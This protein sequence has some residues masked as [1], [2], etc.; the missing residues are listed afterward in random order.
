MCPDF[1]ISIAKKRAKVNMPFPKL[2]KSDSNGPTKLFL[3]KKFVNGLI[4]RLC[5]VSLIYP[6]LCISITS[7]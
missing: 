6:K 5:V 3:D 7:L 1:T 2:L 4:S